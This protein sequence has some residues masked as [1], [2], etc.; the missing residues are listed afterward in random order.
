MLRFFGSLVSGL[1]AVALAVPA[2][3]GSAAS[4]AG[5]E[6]SGAVAAG[7]CPE[8]DYCALRCSG[9]ETPLYPAECTIPACACLPGTT[10]RDDW[11]GTYHVAGAADAVNLVLEADGTFRWTLDGCD[12]GDGDCGVWKKSQ[13][14]TIVLLSSAATANAT[15]AWNMGVGVSETTRLDVSTD[16]SGDLIVSLPQE[17]AKP[18]AQRWVKGRVCA[19]CEGGDGPS[20]QQA[21]TEPVAA[22]CR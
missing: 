4:N 19:I 15:F 6:R 14:H 12:F 5:G 16:A 20:G 7:S 22:R 21:C 9:Q 17:G 1:T 10:P 2:C 3:G 11:A 8:I 18:T 13:P